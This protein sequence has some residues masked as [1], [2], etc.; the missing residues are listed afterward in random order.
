MRTL[1][2]VVLC[3]YGLIG[4]AFAGCSFKD[5]ATGVSYDISRVKKTNPHNFVDLR[6][7][8]ERNF[9]Y[10]VA[11]CDDLPSVP[12]GCPGT[13][14]L[15]AYQVDTITG[16]QH[17][18]ELA[19]QYSDASTSMQLYNAERPAMGVQLVYSQVVDRQAWC[20]T[21]GARQLKVNMLCGGG[22]L[23]RDQTFV[24]EMDTCVYEVYTFSEYG[25]PTG[26]DTSGSEVC[27]GQ[28]I[29]QYDNDLREA[30]CFCYDGFEGEGC[31]HAK[32]KHPGGSIAGAFFGA[33]F[34]ALACVG[35]YWFYRRHKAG[36]AGASAEGF[37]GPAP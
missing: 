1:S 13:T 6:N 14:P 34:L 26:C 2:A 10:H 24:M 36:G 29:C 28:G 32:P 15:P 27:G 22:D 37:Y 23:I 35:G 5:S 30:R 18:Y 16:Q 19:Q 12:A 21:S 7:T 33:F 3:L 9:T 4:V 11:I 31:A 25:C 20:G 8:N 17:C